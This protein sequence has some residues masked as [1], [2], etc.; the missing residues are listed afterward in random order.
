VGEPS[1]VRNTNGAGGLGD[2]FD[3]TPGLERADGEHVI[4]TLT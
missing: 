2:D 1:G 3:R 4:E